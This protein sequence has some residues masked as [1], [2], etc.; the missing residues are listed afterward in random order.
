[1][2]QQKVR[3]WIDDATEPCLVVDRLTIRERGK[4]G[5]WVDSREGAF[6]NLKI[7]VAK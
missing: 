1:M 4:V 5:L 3:A 6:S 2:T 7:L